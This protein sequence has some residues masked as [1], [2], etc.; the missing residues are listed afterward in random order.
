MAGDVYVLLP[1][2]VTG[3]D[4]KTSFSLMQLDSLIEALELKGPYSFQLIVPCGSLPSIVASSLIDW[5][6]LAS[7]GVAFVV[8]FGMVM[9]KGQALEFPFFSTLLSL[10]SL[11]VISFALDAGSP[12]SLPCGSYMTGQMLNGPEV[13]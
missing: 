10:F 7:P 3:V 6:L 12:T 11:A 4:S 1:F 5:P 13:L 8:S 2:T 9:T